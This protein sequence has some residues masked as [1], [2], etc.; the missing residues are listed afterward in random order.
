MCID[1]VYI[2]SLVLMKHVTVG[3]RCLSSTRSTTLHNKHCLPH[4]FISTTEQNNYFLFPS[5]QLKK[6]T[7]THKNKSSVSIHFI[8]YVNWTYDAHCNYN[9]MVGLS[10]YLISKLQLAC[11]RTPCIGLFVLTILTEMIYLKDIPHILKCMQ[12]NNEIIKC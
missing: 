4:V 10:M 1:N 6:H 12:K 2:L 8:K 9:V 11:T 3:D 7:R 5:V